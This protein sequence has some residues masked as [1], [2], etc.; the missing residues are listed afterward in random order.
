MVGYCDCQGMLSYR[1][2]KE[3]ALVL[4]SAIAVL[5]AVSAGDPVFAATIEHMQKAEGQC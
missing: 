4:V 3:T 5:D 1:L 2:E